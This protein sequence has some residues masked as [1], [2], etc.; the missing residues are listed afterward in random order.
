MVNSIIVGRK[1]EEEYKSKRVTVQVSEIEKT[2]VEELAKYYEVTPS[3]MIR[4]W[5]R[6]EY[7]KV[8]GDD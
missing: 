3:V 6:K 7:L 4:Q 2:R 1:K 8:F 5:L